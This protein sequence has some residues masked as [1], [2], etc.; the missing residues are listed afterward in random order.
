MNA[1]TFAKIADASQPGQGGRIGFVRSVSEGVVI[2]RTLGIQGFRP[3]KSR[4]DD[5]GET[6]ASVAWSTERKP[7][8]DSPPGR[9]YGIKLCERSDAP[10]PYKLALGLLKHPNRQLSGAGDR[11]R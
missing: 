11:G 2:P 5:A 1:T 6:M 7:D 10:N 8:C 4:F 9:D 3:K